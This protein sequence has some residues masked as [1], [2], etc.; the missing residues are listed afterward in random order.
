MLAGH[1]IRSPRAG[2]AWEP[3]ARRTVGKRCIPMGLPL[4]HCPVALRLPGIVALA[5]IAI[6]MAVAPRGVLKPRPALRKAADRSDH[7]ADRRRALA[8]RG[9]AAA[10]PTRRH[11]AVD[12]R[13]PARPLGAWRAW[14]EAQHFLFPKSPEQK[15]MLDG[16]AQFGILLLLLLTGMETDLALVRNVRPRRIQRL[17]RRHRAAV[18]LR[19]R[20]RRVAARLRAARSG[21]S[22]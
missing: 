7:P 2:P 1:Q 11:G 16:I 14:P 8:R 15:A 12:R 3:F 18:R 21:A 6:V 5:A 17:A 19:L 22:G 4:K 9:H 10:R 20:A 13:H